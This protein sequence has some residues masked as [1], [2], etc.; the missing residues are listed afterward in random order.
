MLYPNAWFKL[1]IASMHVGKYMFSISAFTTLLKLNPD[2]GEGWSN[3]AG[4]LMKV[5]KYKEAFEAA[6]Q[7]VRF[8]RDNWHVW[9]NFITIAV[10]QR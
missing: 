8:L 7:S 5:H 10:R 4:V 2:F 1:A 6:Q 9:D 3:V